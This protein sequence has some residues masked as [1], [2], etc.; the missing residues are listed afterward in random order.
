MY[1]VLFINPYLKVSIKIDY[2][3]VIC[4]NE[5]CNTNTKENKLKQ[6][7]NISID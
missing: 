6:N 5:K 1:Y 7:K 3:Y 4:N 2:G